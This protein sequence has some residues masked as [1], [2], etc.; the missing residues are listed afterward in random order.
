MTT[1]G[2]GNA[3]A[4]AGDARTVDQNTEAAMAAFEEL[5]EFYRSRGFARSV[6]FGRTP[7]IICVDWINGFTDPHFPTGS[8]YAAELAATRTL[9]D[10]ARERGFP[11]FLVG[12]EYEPQ[13]RDAGVWERKVSHEGLYKGSHWVATDERLGETDDDQSLTKRY[14]SA[15]FMTD[16]T[17]RLVSQGVDTVIVTG[18]TTS[19]CVRAT[20]VDACSSGFRTIVPREAVGDR[21]RLPHVANLFDMEMKYADVLALDEVAQTLTR[22]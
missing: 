15:F 6:G 8:D 1:R 2:T 18:A 11:R 19:G 12:S 9:L 17:A 10:L 3:T 13:R 4:G 22:L 16:L 21:A 5:S 20:A 7:A 14:P